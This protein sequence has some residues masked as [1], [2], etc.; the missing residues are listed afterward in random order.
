MG[1][2]V[3]DDVDSDVSTAMAIET[4]S[5][6]L[7]LIFLTIVFEKTK[8][9]AEHAAG[10]V[11]GPLVDA[12][13]GELTVLGFLSVITFCLEKAGLFLA[14]TKL[15]SQELDDGEDGD[16]D[17]EVF[18]L[19]ESIHFGMFFIMVIFMVTVLTEVRDGLTILKEWYQ[20]DRACQD[21]AYVQTLLKRNA[22]KIKAFDAISSMGGLQG[23][24]QRMWRFLVP[25]FR[26]LPFLRDRRRENSRG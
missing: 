24:I 9:H 7:V 17:D 1:N 4:L 18:E 5:I 14:L 25:Y 15:I 22:T 20:W 3:L 10:R 11:L 16:Q 26:F 6:V 13:F 12:L 2:A 21:E 8:H 19:V 23:V